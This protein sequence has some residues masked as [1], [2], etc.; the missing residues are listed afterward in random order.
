MMH[1]SVCVYRN[2]IK[3]DLDCAEERQVLQFIP[4][5]SAQFDNLQSFDFNISFS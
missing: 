1:L 2:Q 5:R 3:V 4:A